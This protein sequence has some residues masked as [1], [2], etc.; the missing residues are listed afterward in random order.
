MIN[1]GSIFVKSPFK[2]LREHM[3]KVHESVAPLAPFMDALHE[4]NDD[5][6]KQLRLEIQEAEEAADQIKNDIRNHLPHSLFLPIDRR[7]LLAVLDMQDSIADTAQDISDLLELRKMKLPNEMRPDLMNYVGVIEK[8]C[9]LGYSISV[10]FE[11]L[12]ES[13]FGKHHTEKIVTMIDEVGQVESEADDL[14]NQLIRKLFQMET[15]MNAVDVVFW[16][17][18][19]GQIGD[20]AD[21]TEKMAN[22]LRLLVAK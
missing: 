17:Q 9:S 13:G 8:A 22:R 7:D 6:L 15:E 3:K 20:I 2:P 19:F 16:Y 11:A 12:V 18:L 4:G 5:R 14:E 10:D 1:L 21:Y